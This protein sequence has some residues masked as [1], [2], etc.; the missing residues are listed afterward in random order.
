MTETTEEEKT[1]VEK[2]QRGRKKKQKTAVDAACETKGKAV[3]RGKAKRRARRENIQGLT[4][5]AMH[6]IKRAAG[7]ERLESDAVDATRDVAHEFLVK[8]L[9]DAVMVAKHQKRKTIRGDDVQEAVEMQPAGI[10]PTHAP[11]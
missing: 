10:F 3:S 7:V 8:L 1:T 4:R 5:P 11:L 9:T 2:K 6:R